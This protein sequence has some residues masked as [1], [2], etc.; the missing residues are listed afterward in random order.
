MAK[1]PA[2]L[3]L[4]PPSASLRAPALFPPIVNPWNDQILRTAERQTAVAA[5]A[6]AA[7]TELEAMQ[8]TSPLP[9]AAVTPE[10]ARAT[11]RSRSS[12][13]GVPVRKVYDT[14]T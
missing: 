3:P 6:A 2:A 14:S 13:F 10:S 4:S 8:L 1:L 11:P 7:A 12:P 9:V 5:A